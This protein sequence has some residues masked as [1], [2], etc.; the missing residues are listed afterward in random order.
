MASATAG[1]PSTRDGSQS[2]P[3][4]PLGRRKREDEPGGDLFDRIMKEKIHVYGNGKRIAITRCNASART[5]VNRG[6]A[7]DTV[8]ENTLIKIE[9]PALAAR[10]AQGGPVR[11][12][13]ASLWHP[14]DRAT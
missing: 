2:S 7:G 13:G 14:V 1:R 12:P 4:I 10:L 9:G 11:S 8:F 3:A 5:V 6:I